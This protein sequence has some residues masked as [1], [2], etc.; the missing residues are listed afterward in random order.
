MKSITRLLILLLALPS[1]NSLAGQDTATPQI[2]KSQ[3]ILHKVMDDIRLCDKTERYEYDDKSERISPPEVAKIKGFRLK[4][5]YR[6]VAVFNVNETYLGLHVKAVT[7]GKAGNGYPYS[8]LSVAFG[9]PYPRVRHRL[10]REWGVKFQDRTLPGPEYIEDAEYAETEVIIG[11]KRRVLSI[12][13]T[14][15]SI[16]PFIGLPDVGCNQGQP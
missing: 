5:N 13:Q 2:T 1:L 8:I 14:P 9:D 7:L 6:E 15:V 10:E 16:Y 12:E 4:K 11:T 3:Q